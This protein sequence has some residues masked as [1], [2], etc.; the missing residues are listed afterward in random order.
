MSTPTPP[1][2]I[3]ATAR[4]LEWRFLPPHVRSLVESRCGSPVVDAA[5]QNSGFTPGFASVLTCADGSK[6]FVKAASVKAQRLFA[7][8]YREEARKLGALPG[9]V[10]A[11]RLLWTH[12]DD[13]VVLGIEYVDGRNPSRP[14]SVADLDACLDTAESVARDLTPPPADLRLDPFAEVLADWPRLWDQVRATRPELAQADEAAAL[15]GRFAEVTG[16]STVVHTDLR[17]DNLLVDAAG[18]VWICDWNWPVLGAD[19]LDT[20]FLLIGPRG[21]G[22]DV[23][24]ILRSRPLTRD[25]PEEHV[26]ICLAL[27]TGYFFKSSSDPVPPTSPHLREF[28]AWQGE[29][30]WQWLG[31]RRGWT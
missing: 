30:C 23:D 9:S 21:D 11:P 6:H 18:K 14:W 19:W 27:V 22:L 1:V 25:V 24:A 3:G 4:R 5:T 10:P 2:P 29:V 20:L 12:D 17:D 7:D 16:G 26:D 13:W 15:A 31:E 8:S 28:Q